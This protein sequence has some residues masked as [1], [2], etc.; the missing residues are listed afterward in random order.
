[1]G[2]GFLYK[3]VFGI[4]QRTTVQR[5]LYFP[6]HYNRECDQDVKFEKYSWN[7]QYN[8]QYHLIQP[9][10]IPGR[11]LLKGKS[12]NLLGIGS[13]RCNE[14]NCTIKII[15]KPLI[16]GV[17]P[18]KMLLVVLILHQMSYIICCMSMPILF[19]LPCHSLPVED[20][21]RTALIP[22]GDRVTS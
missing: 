11:H 2:G 12:L 8:P 14:H 5:F 15:A 20:F 19:I 17:N 1:M 9:V 13:F 6:H 3:H 7:I 22:A 18:N 16:R 21:T 10:L 4:M